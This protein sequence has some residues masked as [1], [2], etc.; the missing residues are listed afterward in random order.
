MIS[1]KPYSP[2]CDRNRE[3]IAAVIL[4]LFSCIET[5]LEIGSG[6]AQHA[7]YF[8]G[9]MPHL[10][11]QTSDLACNHAG[12]RK[13]IQ[14]AALPN[15]LP[16]LS[17]NVDDEFW[18]VSHVDAV[19]TANTLHIAAWTSVQNMFTGVSR[20]LDRGGL[21]CIYGPFRYHGLHT[22]ESNA[23][24]DASLRLNDSSSGIR[25][26]DDV[27]DLARRDLFFLEN[28]YRMPANNRLLVFRK[29]GR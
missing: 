15:V 4:P 22:S 27:L 5:V 10:R 18:P 1:D 19:F 6:T 11:W 17:L 28:D 9:L 8:G 12:M 7:V 25:D 16:P 2:A 21:F 20:L 13:W 3:P 23:C 26:I 14:E 24:F 29:T